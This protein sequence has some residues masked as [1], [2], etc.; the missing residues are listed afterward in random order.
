M[1]LVPVVSAIRF[2]GREGSCTL[3]WWLVRA[4]GVRAGGVV[5]GI[6]A[7]SDHPACGTDRRLSQSL[8]GR[9]RCLARSCRGR[10]RGSGPGRDRRRGHCQ[11]IWDVWQAIS[12]IITGQIRL[13]HDVRHRFVTTPL[14][15]NDD[16]MHLRRRECDDAMMC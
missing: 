1:L 4:V 11:L 12:N 5:V 9:D 6:T 8:G 7:W 15:V 3:H 13:C 2:V 14:C 16:F 10:S